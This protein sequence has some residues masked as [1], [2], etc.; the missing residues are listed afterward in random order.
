[1]ALKYFKEDKKLILLC[2]NRLKIILGFC[3]YKDNF[4]MRLL[5]DIL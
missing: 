3:L 1:M 4:L 2:Y 5:F